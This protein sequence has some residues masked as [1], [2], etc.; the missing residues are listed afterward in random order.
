MATQLKELL[1]SNTINISCDDISKFF[2]SNDNANLTKLLINAIFNN[3]S[4]NGKIKHLHNLLLIKTENINDLLEEL[5]TK[6]VPDIIKSS[7][8]NAFNTEQ[9]IPLLH[10]ILDYVLDSS[11]QNII[12]DIFNIVEKTYLNND[13]PPIFLIEMILHQNINFRTSLLKM[14]F[15]SNLD[16]SEEYSLVCRK[17]DILFSRIFERIVYNHSHIDS[18]DIKVHIPNKDEDYIYMSQ[19]NDIFMII[20]A[21]NDDDEGAICLHNIIGNVINNYPEYI[22][23]IKYV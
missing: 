13:E 14:L 10:K 22:Y 17:K 7:L 18:D 2:P 20:V 19:Y 5:V 4:P 11:M 1:V 12:M 16:I 15:K 9:N 8:E 21:N 23:F 3:E 6:Y